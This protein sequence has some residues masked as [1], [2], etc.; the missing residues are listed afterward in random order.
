M[1]C[2]PGGLNGT[3]RHLFLDF[4]LLAS[5]CPCQ[6]RNAFGN[7]AAKRVA[8]EN[9]FTFSLPGNWRLYVGVSVCACVENA[10]A[11]KLG[12]GACGVRLCKWCLCAW[13][14]LANLGHSEFAVPSIW[15]VCLLRLLA[16]CRCARQRWGLRMPCR[17]ETDGAAS[18]TAGLTLWR[19]GRGT[20]PA[21]R[22][23]WDFSHT[24]LLW[25]TPAFAH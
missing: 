7:L 22:P 10:C 2:L 21:A 17:T 19:W 6:T 13:E 25:G 4:P 12:L 8:V 15:R 9:L 1:V 23:I 11:P 14:T 18:H 24:A 20:P 3:E 5:P 16:P